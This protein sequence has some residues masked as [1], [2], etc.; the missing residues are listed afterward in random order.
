MPS[1]PIDANLAASSAPSQY[2][3]SP[4]GAARKRRTQLDP[5]RTRMAGS[6]PRSNDRPSA[7][8]A[9]TIDS[10]QLTLTIPPPIDPGVFRSV[11]EIRRLV[12]DATE[13]ALRA[14]SGLV[15][16]GSPSPEQA[17]SSYM[18]LN[19]FGGSSQNS[20]NGKLGGRKSTLSTIRA[21]RMRALAV[22][23]LAE[24]YRLDEIATCVLVMKGTS[25]FEDLAERVLRQGSF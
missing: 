17:Y 25:A 18:R 19:G 10:N 5:R 14:A 3:S 11:K 23:K 12:D 9:D 8:P 4:N 20:V 16:P 22:Q 1:I 7:H 2:S 21:N 6:S 15:D 13:L 24:A